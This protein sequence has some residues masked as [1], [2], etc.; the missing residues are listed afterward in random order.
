MGKLGYLCRSMP[1]DALQD[2]ATQYVAGAMTAPERE[3]FEVLLEFHGDLGRQVASLLDTS[4]AMALTGTPRATPPT[5]LRA[6][7]LH[8]LDALPP[9]EGPESRVVTDARGLVEW[10]NPAF[11]DMCGYTLSELKGRK[12]GAVLQGPE[13]DQAAVTR[14]REALQA[15]QACRETVVNYHKDGS[16]Y[17][18]DIRMDP[19][20][21]E[22]GEPLWFV[23]RERKLTA[24]AVAV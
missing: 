17:R 9:R 23:A 24:A 21:D 13:T 22:A 4:A 3:A 2:K 8:T 1:I 6:R 11:T 14:I 18:A 16:T 19:I 12:P 20:L 10:I 15:R 7:I 5:T